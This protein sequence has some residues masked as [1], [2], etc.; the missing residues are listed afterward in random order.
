M[1]WKTSSFF[2]INDNLFYGHSIFLEVQSRNGLRIISWDYSTFQIYF[3]NSIST[4][5][6]VNSYLLFFLK[7]VEVI[8]LSETIG[9]FFFQDFKGNKIYCQRVL[10]IRLFIKNSFCFISYIF[11]LFITL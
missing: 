4:I 3:L 5:S 7:P 11:F 9:H 1:N 2:L 8:K 6:M 10:H